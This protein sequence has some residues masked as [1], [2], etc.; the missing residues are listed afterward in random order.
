MQSAMPR[1]LR[2]T[3]VP[4]FGSKSSALGCQCHAGARSG[5]SLLPGAWSWTCGLWVMLFL[6]HSRNV[7]PGPSTILP[8]GC[9]S[10]AEPLPELSMKSWPVTSVHLQKVLGLDS[11]LFCIKGGVIG[12]QIEWDC[13]LDKAPSECYPR[14]YFNRLDNRFSGNSISSGYNFR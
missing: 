2:G 3:L 6:N 9:C 13:D 14:Y 10:G 1:L 5:H 4:A 12:I 8:E 11:C 7:N